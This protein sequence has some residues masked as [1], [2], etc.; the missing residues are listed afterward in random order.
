MIL[1]TGGTG[2]VGSHLLLELINDKKKVRA[3]FRNKDSIKKVKQLFKWNNIPTAFVDEKIEWIKTDLLNPEDLKKCFN[4]VQEVYHCAAM[5]SFNKKDKNLLFKTNIEGTANIVNLSLDFGIKK[6]C[7]V[8]STAA[9]GKAPKNEIRT[10]DCHW[11]DD[12]V[13]NYAVS[14]YLAEMEVWRGVEEGLNAVIVNPSI[15]IGPGDWN[16]SSSNLFLKV[17]NGL[18][19]YSKGGNAFVDVRDVVKIMLALTKSNINAERFLVISENLSFRDLFNQIAAS[20][21]KPL[22]SIKAKKWMVGLIWRLDMLKSFVLGTTPLV[23]K[24]SAKSAM[25][26]ATYSNKKIKDA[27]KFDF[28]PIAAAIKHTSIYFLRDK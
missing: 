26:T 2:L 11:Q 22:P 21:N 24:E 18:K 6:L 28:I 27:L 3:T 16:I 13:S 23:T 5:V 14:K 19:F 7:Y 15:I 20:I 10:E 8:S 25:N 4:E 9:I 17:W 1:V 12:G